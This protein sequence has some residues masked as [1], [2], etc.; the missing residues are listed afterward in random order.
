MSI[1]APSERLQSLDQFRGYTVAGMF[2]V[3]FMGSYA[4]CPYIWKHSHNYCS[5]ADTIMPHFLFASG[6]ALRLSFLK[7]QKHGGG[8]EAWFRMVR[9]CIGLALFAIVWY[10]FDDWDGISKMLSERGWLQTLGQCL[11]RN[12]MQTLLHIAITSLWI[13]P[14]ISKPLG[15]RVAYAVVS[16]IAHIGL[17]YWFNYLWS[18]SGGIDGGP[19]GFLTWCIPAIAGTW[20]YDVVQAARKATPTG[21]GHQL[22]PAIRRLILVG[23]GICL[24]GWLISWP[25]TIYNV[26]DDQVEALKSEKFAQNPVIPSAEQLK[27]WKFQPSELPFVPPPDQDHR[28]WNYWM[29]SQRGGTL[30]YP[31]FAAGFSLLVMAF[32]LWF[33]DV[34]GIRVGVFRTLGVNALLAYI[35][36]GFFAPWALKLSGKIYGSTV[37]KQSG[38]W[39]VY[40]AFFLMCLMIYLVL[41]ILEWRKI[42]L[43]M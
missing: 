1:A 25:T 8:H 38:P 23:L 17:S 22:M 24:L 34:L 27:A 11:K 43:R 5:Y 7:H 40:T 3:N 19:L 9:R 16:G 26:P 28:K 42:Y 13:L 10:S 36:P 35:L 18:N 31:T 2:L 30:S 33:S 39:E 20:A 21:N 32:F 37:D 12:W 4:V 15:I 14:V 41:R 29:M 6:F